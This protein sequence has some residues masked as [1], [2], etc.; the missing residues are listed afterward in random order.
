MLKNL[1]KPDHPS[2]LG[3][4]LKSILFCHLILFLFTGTALCQYKDTTYSFYKVSSIDNN[5]Y[6]VSTA[7]SADFVKVMYPANEAKNIIPVTQFYSDGKVNFIGSYSLSRYNQSKLTILDGDFIAFYPDGKRRCYLHYING[8]KDGLGYFFYPNGRAYC[9]RKFGQYLPADGT[10][11]ECYD[12]NGSLICKKGNGQWIIYDDK[13][14]PMI[15]GPINNELPD[16]EW[17]GETFEADSIKYTYIYRKGKLISGTGYDKFGKQYPFKEYIDQSSVNSDPFRFIRKL[18]AN[19]K[20]PNNANIKISALDTAKV[21]FILEKDGRFTNPEIIGNNDPA[22]RQALQNAL[23]KFTEEK[24]MKYYGIPLR[25]KI[26]VSFK[27]VSETHTSNY[28]TA[29]TPAP[30]LWEFE[31]PYGVQDP[32]YVNSSYTSTTKWLNFKEEIL[33]FD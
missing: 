3:V 20:I 17:H 18:R 9:S 27:D 7:D 4:I 30:R 23:D 16:G 13:F 15:Q 14:R 32:Y 29:V 25:S 22:L 26:T 21:S 12:N 24:P 1:P 19:F 6:K 10:Y 2:L 5:V 8:M 33:G 31:S 11:W 28:S